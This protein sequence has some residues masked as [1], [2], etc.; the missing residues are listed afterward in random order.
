MKTGRTDGHTE[1]PAGDVARKRAY[2]VVDAFLWF[3]DRRSNIE[4]L[5]DNKGRYSLLYTFSVASQQTIVTLI[6]L[7]QG[8][9]K[10]TF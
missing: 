10:S 2:V 3:C 1:K 7:L 4:T 6:S 5:S 8:V 9:K